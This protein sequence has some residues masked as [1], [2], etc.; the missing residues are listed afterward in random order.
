MTIVGKN[1]EKFDRN[2]DRPD[3]SYCGPIRRADCTRVGGEA[4]GT[5][6]QVSVLMT[7]TG[8][9]AKVLPWDR[10]LCRHSPTRRC[11]GDIGCK[12][13]PHIAS[14]W[15]D[16][17]PGR[18]HRMNDAA[19]RFAVN[20]VGV[21]ALIVLWVVEDQKRG[22]VHRH[23]A[24]DLST[25]ERRAA[26]RA[27]CHFVQR[28]SRFYA[29]G[30]L[31]PGDDRRWRASNA[32]VP[33]LQEHD[34]AGRTRMIRYMAKYM[35]KGMKS[36]WAVR[37]SGAGYYVHREATYRT[38]ITRG[39]LKR[40]RYAWVLAKKSAGELPLALAALFVSQNLGPVA[41]WPR[42]YGLEQLDNRP[43]RAPPVPA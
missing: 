24:F 30:A 16:S 38:N 9:G 21:R 10:S 37:Y 27:W 41:G 32:A 1:G 14:P 23:F 5:Y 15:N 42:D 35:A 4:L 28:R 43:R 39:S 20:H 2:C 12:V 34:V 31:V 7:L 29:Y 18:W 6:A 33:A 17:E 11:S 3:C 19:Q 22:V 13:L 8:P 36:L 40:A 25:P 26:A